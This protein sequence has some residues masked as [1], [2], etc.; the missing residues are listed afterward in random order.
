MFNPFIENR[1]EEMKDLWKYY[2][3][4]SNIN[5]ERNKAIVVQGPRGSGKTMLF[6]CN[7]WKEVC[8][9]A[10]A[11]NENILST[12]REKKFIGF[13]YKSDSSFV[14]SMNGDT[15]KNWQNIF[16]T[17][18]SLV[19]LQEILAFVNYLNI[20]TEIKKEKIQDFFSYVGSKIGLENEDKTFKYLSLEIEKQLDNIQDIV[21]NYDSQNLRKSYNTDRFLFELDKQLQELV[22]FPV[23]AKIFIDEYE[24]FTE[25]QQVIINTLIKRSNAY[26]VYN[27]GLRK[28]GIKTFSTLAASESIKSP[29]DFE[30]FDLS[31]QDDQYQQILINI[32]KKRLSNAKA[33][34]NIPSDASEN[35]QDYL[36]NYDFDEE[37][38]LITCSKIKP[39]FY[40]KLE[41]VIVEI[42][43]KE[44]IPDSLILKYVDN[45]CKNAEPLNARLHY[46]LLIRKNKYSP[47]LEELYKA[48]NEKNAKYQA[49]LHNRK[50]GIIFL[51]AKEYQKSKLYFGFDCYAFISDGT[52]R[53]FLELCEQLFQI[54]S[55]DKFKWGQ[56]RISSKLQSSA[57]KYISE[58]R[59]SDIQQ[60][61][62]DGFK[63]RVFIQHLGQI[64]KELH[65]D[66]NTTLGEPEPNHFTTDWLSLNESC[67]N[68]LDNAVMQNVLIRKQATKQKEALKSTDVYDFYINKIYTPYF[69]ISYRNQRKIKIGE[70][71]LILLMSGNTEDA[72][73][74]VRDL[75]HKDVD[76][77]LQ[78]DFDLLFDKDK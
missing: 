26:V 68:F 34:K 13:Y 75:L 44:K 39:S 62:P 52:I 38:K 12:L 14:Y 1:S 47:T 30:Q 74:G 45:L 66:E 73:K 8:N 76:D 20:S 63:L 21:N 36:G 31:I 16:E 42:G 54:A 23:T 67:H 53:I 19:L 7:S 78:P 29:D 55:L 56:E 28:N 40:D 41:N 37:L 11:N 33:E 60:I 77:Q 70:K 71:Y 43:K 27:I 65:Y 48:Y 9:Q 49:W 22:G 50:S 69:G 32:C 59:I 64:F 25:Y 61:K 46:T 58:L 15:K 2:V 51:L 18:L 5:F 4:I 24:S 3:S 72:K 57:A 6:L 17:Y 10:I 35:I